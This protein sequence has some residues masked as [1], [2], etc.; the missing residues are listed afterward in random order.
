ISSFDPPCNGIEIDDGCP[1]AG[2]SDQLANQLN[3]LELRIDH[4]QARGMAEEIEDGTM[5]DGPLDGQAQGAKE[6]IELPA[7]AAECRN[8]ADRAHG[9]LNKSLGIGERLRGGLCLHDRIKDLA[10]RLLAGLT[11]GMGRVLATDPGV[12]L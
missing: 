11:H 2:L 3:R 8:I 4:I 6:M 9:N 10:C 1:F 5:L 7:T 12:T